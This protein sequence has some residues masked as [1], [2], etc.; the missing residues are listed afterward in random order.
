[1]LVPNVASADGHSSVPPFVVAIPS[2][3]TLQIAVKGHC[4]D[5]G[6]PF[7]GTNITP[8]ETA[9]DEIRLAI[10][11]GV[12]HGY[13]TEQDLEQVQR[14]IW[15]FTDGLDITGDEDAV[16]REIVEFA[17][18]GEPMDLTDEVNSFSDA[19]DQG[20][21]KVSLT[22]FENQSDPPYFGTGMLVIENRTDASIAINIPYGV[23]FEDRTQEGVQ[24]MA[25][26][27]ATLPSADPDQGSLAARE[28]TCHPMSIKL[29]AQKSVD[30]LVHGYC[31]DYGAP[32]PGQELKPLEL[33]P[34]VIRNTVCYNIAKGYVEDEIWQAQLAI[35]RQTDELDKGSEFPLVDEIADYAE[36][37][38]EPGDMGQDCVPLPDAVEDGLISADVTE[39]VNT[40]DPEY[41]GKGKMTLVNLTD[42]EQNICLPYATAYKDETQ[43][44]VQDMAVY[45]D[46]RPDP[47]DLEEPQLLPESG[48][49]MSN[50]ELYSLLL[51]AVGVLL[52]GSGFALRR[53]KRA[54]KP[55]P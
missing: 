37:G 28:S 32:F 55:V 9:E 50:S 21:I 7:P 6:L 12:V 8:V 39:F 3:G 22:D 54:H 19:L 23:V 38:V 45:P 18:T 24:D 5:Y 31:M 1:M 27:P 34:D 30:V 16:A 36:S 14:A 11:Y 48:N 42:E 33:A 40:T 44:G 2:H 47:Q 41:F 4:M 15:H 25:V 51:L 26:F 35:W 43:T 17:K 49:L 10:V 29:P 52:A 20:W 13:Y 53:L 46:Q